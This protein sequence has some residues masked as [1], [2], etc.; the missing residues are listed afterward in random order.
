MV[1]TVAIGWSFKFN[2]FLILIENFV[3][4]LM[5]LHKNIIRNIEFECNLLLVEDIIM[6]V[7]NTTQTN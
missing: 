3:S 7:V 4:D 5:F 6:F 2:I 1:K